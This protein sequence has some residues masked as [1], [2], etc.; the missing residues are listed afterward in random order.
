MLEPGENSR[1]DFFF[2]AHAEVLRAWTGRFVFVF[3]ELM[4]FGETT[5]VYSQTCD[6]TSYAD[7]GPRLCPL[8]DKN[9]AASIFIIL[10]YTRMLKASVDTD[11]E[12]L[13]RNKSVL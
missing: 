1:I 12:N 11:S 2:F 3:I 6:Y 8:N 5:V 7:K 9:I 10:A 13:R 4:L